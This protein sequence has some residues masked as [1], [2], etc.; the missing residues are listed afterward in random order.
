MV[1]Y[2]VYFHP[3]SKFAGPW[4]AAATP[5]PFALRILNG[6]IVPWT[7]SL[8]RKY[9]ETV[10]I[11]P[12]ELSFANPSAWRDIYGHR[13]QLPKA[14]VS[15]GRSV[16]GVLPIIVA[17]VDD[18]TRQRKIVSPAFSDRALR[19]QEYI[20]HDYTDLLISRLHER[21]GSAIDICEW[22]Q[23]TTFDIMGDLCFGDSFNCL[24]GAKY[25]PWMKNLFGSL[26]FGSMLTAFQYF[27]PMDAV[28]YWCIP[29]FVI[30][31]AQKQYFYARDKIT[32]RME[33]ETNRPDFMSY[34]LQNNEKGYMT[35]EEIDASVPIL[36]LAGSDSSAL[37][38]TAALFYCMQNPQVMNKLRDEIEGAFA[39]SSDITV[40]A[41]SSLPYLHAVLCEALRFFPAT[42]S[43]IPREVIAG[44]ATICGHFVPEGVRL[45]LYPLRLD[46]NTD[47][48]DPRRYPR[49]NSFPPPPE[50][51]R[52]R[53][54][55]PRT[56]APGCRF[57]IRCR[58]QRYLGAFC[59]RASKLLGQ[60]V[61]P[62]SGTLITGQHGLIF[63]RLAW[64]EMNM[65]TAKLIWNFEFERT[66][67]FDED[68]ANQ[69]VFLGNARTPLMVRLKARVSQV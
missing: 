52:S 1:T 34:I 47:Q 20:L 2:N 7:T 23:F 24:E 46:R 6:H 9:G 60:T 26:K 53:L 31:K 28:V 59:V 41:A 33:R 3:L 58:S 44:G 64:A 30:A 13:P 37:T 32:E 68:W 11:S 29:K 69:K 36:L 55:P 12:D 38:S 67:G 66:E 5:F 18:H 35:R 56:L 40:E 14:L 16:N 22:C 42:P 8:H 17:H 15:M 45:V 48:S 65:I 27:P 51:C 10:R 61:R 49:E 4:S 57:P 62:A 63:P 19:E 50:L 21:V 25:H 43:A 39:S 54:F